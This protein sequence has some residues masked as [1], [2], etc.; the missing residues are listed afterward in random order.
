MLQECSS[1]MDA[2]IYNSESKKQSRLQL[3]E[4]QMLLNTLKKE[5]YES[6]VHLHYSAILSSMKNHE[7]ALK[8][9]QIALKKGLECMKVC[10]KACIDH[11]TR[12][13]K[14]INTLSIRKRL[15]KQSQYNLLESPHYQNFHKLVNSVIPFLQYFHN[16][17]YTNSKKPVK[18]SMK[19]YL[20]C[21]YSNEDWAN[22]VTMTEV[23]AL[24]PLDPGD[25]N[26]PPGI[27]TEISKESMSNKLVLIISEMFSIASELKHSSNQKEEAKGWHKRTIQNAVELLPMNSNIIKELKENYSKQYKILDVFPKKNRHH[28]FSS[29]VRTPMPAK[30][31]KNPIRHKSHYDKNLELE[32]SSF[33]NPNGVKGN[34]HEH[35]IST[36]PQPRPRTSYSIDRKKSKIESD[37]SKIPDFVLDSYDLYQ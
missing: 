11:L 20:S 17:Y 35:K 14:L 28:T 16:K 22:S 31:H 27:H 33:K 13:S 32:K 21:Y 5:K 9:A 12:H 34:Y 23:T 37:E 25:I 18:I 4:P 15:Q 7:E 2:C 36:T 3:S 26:V 19:S 29:R 10:Y 30:S 1:Y 24:K 6:A 8:H